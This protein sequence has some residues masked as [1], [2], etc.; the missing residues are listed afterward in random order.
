[1]NKRNGYVH[2]TAE[3]EDEVVIGDEARV[4]HHAHVRRGAAV[5]PGGILGKN[6]FVDEGV[7]IGA[8][9]KVQNNVSVYRGVELGEDVFVGPSAVFT[10]DPRPRSF[11]TTWQITPTLVRRGASIGAN[12][13]V[14]C[15]VEIGQYAM[16]AAGSVVTRSVAPHQLVAGNPA[17]PRGWVCMCGAVV[18]RE[19]VCPQQTSCSDCDQTNAE[20]SEDFIPIVRVATGPEAEKLVIEV[21][22]SGRLAQGRKVAELEEAFA[23]AQGVK[24][25]VAVSNGTVALV[26]AL[27]ALGIGPGNEVITTPFSF[28]A[29]L[30]AIIEVGATAR[31]ADI[32][33][34]YNVDVAS[35]AALINEKTAALLPVHLYGLPADMAAIAELAAR[36]DLAVIEDAAQAHGATVEGKGVGSFGVGTFSL[37]GT[38]NITAGEGGLVATDDGA[39]AETLRLLRNQG[40]R[41]RYDYALAGYNWR[42]TDLQAAVAIPQVR[43]LAEINAARNANA[44]Y[45]T[46]LLRGT[47]GLVLPSVPAGRTHVWNQYTVRLTAETLIDR[48]VFCTKLHE[49]GV[50][51]GV[52]Y[53]RLMHDYP[54]YQGDPRVGQEATPV[55]QRMCAGVVSLPI[56]PG[57]VEHDLDRVATTVKEVLG[58]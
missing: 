58:A 20:T 50:G 46:E 18:S 19:A 10:N 42:L 38:K 4:W 55:A 43:R 52:Y 27:K 21:L 9:T 41:A 30:N 33:E 11:N 35:M 48:E 1:M 22:R 13:T 26:A 3:V 57:V 17:R 49:L 37:Y 51:S 47:P 32:G 28:N 56:H 7:Q 23:A 31:F 29:T 12:A 15:G 24:H 54:C 2:P 45:L 25:V 8:R 6:V 39:V 40:M 14:V 16:V 34:D 53:P 36:H 5:G 44:A